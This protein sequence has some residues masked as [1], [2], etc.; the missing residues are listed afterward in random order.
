MKHKNAFKKDKNT[1]KY[2][3]TELNVYKIYDK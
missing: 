1:E 3:F 2:I